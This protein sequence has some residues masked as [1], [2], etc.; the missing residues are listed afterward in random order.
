[1]GNFLVSNQILPTEHGY[2]SSSTVCVADID[3]DNDLD[4]FV[5]ER[6]I[7]NAYGKAGSGFLLVNDG[8]GKFTEKSDGLA[9]NFKDLGM[10]T[11]ALFIDLNNNGFKDLVVVGEFMG[12]QVF[13]N[14]K[15]E[16]SESK[17]AQ[18]SNLKG[19]WNTIEQSDLDNDGDI[20]LIVGN[21]GLNSRFRATEN[22]PITLYANDFDGNGY[23][24]P[25]L[26]FTENNGKQYPYAL[27]HNLVDQLKY[28]S[29]Q[30]PDYESFKNATINDIFT[31]EQLDNSVVLE[32]STLSSVMIINKGDFKF[33][34]KDLPFETQFSPVYAIN[35][36]DFDNDGDQDILLGGNLNGVMPEYGRYDASFS[37]YLENMGSGNF[38]YHQ[39]GKGL[40]IKGQIRDIKVIDEKVFIAKNNDSLEVYKY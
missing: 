28:L 36:H 38:K 6:A 19:W 35:T 21:H 13:E 9:P 17:S 25:I 18:L 16:F 27:R 31:K 5:G 1:L 15:G 4:L 8:T 26:T 10:I 29:K 37:S 12:I 3:N 14:N 22:E 23:V 20:D 24:D 34:V 11:D 30:Y 2:H 40:N 7:P 39:T 32:A 33:E